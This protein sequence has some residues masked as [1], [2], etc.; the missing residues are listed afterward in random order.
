M[1]LD[2][3]VRRV[4]RLPDA[5]EIRLA[6]RRTRRAIRLR[7]L[8]R[9]AIHGEPRPAHDR[10]RDHSNQEPVPHHFE[11]FLSASS[12]A[13]FSSS[14]A[15]TSVLY[16]PKLPSWHAC[17]KIGPTVFFIADSAVHGLVHIVG[18]SIVNLYSMVSSATRVNR[19]MTFKFSSEPRNGFFPL[20]FVV[21][22]TSV[23]PSHRPRDTPIH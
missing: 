16:R 14:L 8:R 4:H 1:R 3:P 22:T 12:A 11:P 21:S 13:F 2:V 10:R 17:S 15:P 7:L 18:S 5:V 19:S 6:I 23:S 20:K 9:H